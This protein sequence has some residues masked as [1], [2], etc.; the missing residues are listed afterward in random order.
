MHRVSSD[1]GGRCHQEG[2]PSLS[3]GACSMLALKGMSPSHSRGPEPRTGVGALDCKTFLQ[4]TKGTHLALQ[5]SQTGP[6]GCK[7]S[8]QPPPALQ[9]TVL[10]LLPWA[11]KA[12]GEVSISHHRLLSGLEASEQYPGDRG[13]ALLACTHSQL[14]GRAPSPETS[15]PRVP[16]GRDWGKVSTSPPGGYKGRRVSREKGTNKK[17]C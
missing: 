16:E 2:S 6:Q 12:W 17:Y 8:G 7:A 1:L 5:E 10:L 15:I 13:W 4:E 11:L 14:S 3:W 9:L